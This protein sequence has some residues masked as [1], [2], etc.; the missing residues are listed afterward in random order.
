M[1][2]LNFTKSHFGAVK[3]EHGN[4]FWLV[5]TSNVTVKW[6]ALLH[7]RKFPCSNTGTQ[8]SYRPDIS[9]FFQQYNVQIIH[10]I[11]RNPHHS[12]DFPVHYAQLLIV[13]IIPRYTVWAAN[14]T[15]EQNIQNVPKMLAQTSKVFHIKIKKNIPTNVSRNQRFSSLI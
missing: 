6:L 12:L 14:S 13:V 15:I 11:R 2:G 4:K 8:T 1:Y 5:Y 10:R 7:I 9:W 3:Y